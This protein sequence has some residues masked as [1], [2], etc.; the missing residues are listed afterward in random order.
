M[1]AAPGPQVPA[2]RATPE[3]LVQLLVNIAGRLERLEGLTER[4][5]EHTERVE[6][7]FDAE[8]I[9]FVALNDKVALLCVIASSAVSRREVWVG[10]ACAV[11]AVVLLFGVSAALLRHFPWLVGGL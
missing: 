9:R 8:Q 1:T 7:R 2:T 6:R 5:A 10:V 3:K 11:F 4:L